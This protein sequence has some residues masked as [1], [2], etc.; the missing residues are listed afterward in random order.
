MAEINGTEF[1]K[2][3]VDNRTFSIDII[4][5]P[6]GD[7]MKRN[8]KFADTYYG[9]HHMICKE[10]LREIIE[11]KPQFFVIG[12]GQYNGCRLEESVKRVCEKNGIKLIT[13]TTPKAIKIFNDIPASKAGLFHVTC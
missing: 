12:L 10:E 4:I 13:E 7:V 11:A 9:T 2:I 3:T 6:N 5:M 1:G 8:I